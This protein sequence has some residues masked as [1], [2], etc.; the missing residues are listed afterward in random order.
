[1]AER[2]GVERIKC[3]FDGV[4]DS[5]FE[6][7]AVVRHSRWNE[8]ALWWAERRALVVPEAVGTSP[9]FR[10]GSEPVGVHPMMRIKPPRD[11]LGRFEPEHL[12]TGHGTGMH[13][14]G[15]AAAL[16]NCLDGAR[17]RIPRAF[18]SLLRG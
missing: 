7:V 10:A 5:S 4:P 14:P 9:Y 3:P 1:V 17:R 8:V 6:S 18:V 13:G 16:S 12:L 2:L 15:T 11:Q